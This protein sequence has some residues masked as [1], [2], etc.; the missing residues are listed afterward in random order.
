MLFPVGLNKIDLGFARNYLTSEFPSWEII[1]IKRKE[2]EIDEPH[3]RKKIVV[4]EYGVT[5]PGSK[6]IKFRCFSKQFQ[7]WIYVIE[8]LMIK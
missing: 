4:A 2:F 5:P 1:D 8:P 6:T 3:N 7:K